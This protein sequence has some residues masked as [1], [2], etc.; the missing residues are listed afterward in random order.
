MASHSNNTSFTNI[1]IIFNI[2]ISTNPC[3]IINVDFSKFRKTIFSIYIIISEILHLKQQRLNLL[4]VQVM[5][6]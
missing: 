4:G 5:K 1:A 6:H 2:N 3:I